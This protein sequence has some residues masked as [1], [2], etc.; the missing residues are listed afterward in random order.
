MDQHSERGSGT[1]QYN[2]LKKNTMYEAT[3]YALQQHGTEYT[4]EYLVLVAV[5]FEL[6]CCIAKC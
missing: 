6:G 4:G 3:Q 2:T 5:K 1:V